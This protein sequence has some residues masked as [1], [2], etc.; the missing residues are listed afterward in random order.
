MCFDFLYNV[1]SETFLILSKIQLDIVI[2]VRGSS[3]SVPVILVRLMKPEFSG[4]IFEKK[5]IYSNAKFYENPY[6]GGRVV[7][8]GQAR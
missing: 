5:K 4:Q 7:P 2:N 3:C 6:S 1:L 8:C